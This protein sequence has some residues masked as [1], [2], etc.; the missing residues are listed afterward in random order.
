M[1]KRLTEVIGGVGF[2]LAI[3]GFLWLA[4]VVGHGDYLM[5]I[6]KDAGEAFGLLKDAIAPLVVCFVGVALNNISD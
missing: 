2:A 4:G 6:G 1:Q 5:E 3:V